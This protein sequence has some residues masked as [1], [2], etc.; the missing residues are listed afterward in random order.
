MRAART[1]TA[2]TE[3]HAPPDGRDDP[4]T[5]AEL[6]DTELRPGDA[7]VRLH[8]PEF[9]VVTRHLDAPAGEIASDYGG[10]LSDWVSVEDDTAVVAAV[11][12]DRL[13]NC[14]ARIEDNA[15]IFQAV[16][17][18]LVQQRA[19]PKKWLVPAVGE[20]VDAKKRGEWDGLADYVEEE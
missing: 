1:E 14:P 9:Y 4:D 19:V 6:L 5:V 16:A 2:A 12:L 11:P 3:P 17:D 13:D 20:F 7:A 8:R 18:G 10:S 15:S